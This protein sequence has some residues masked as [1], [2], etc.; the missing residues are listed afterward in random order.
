[1]KRL[2]TDT[3]KTLLRRKAIG[4]A[5][6]LYGEEDYLKN[7]SAERVVSAYV[8]EAARSF[9]FTELYR[10]LDIGRLRD[11][12]MALPMLSEKRV[13][14]L[15]DPDI[16]SGGEE[17]AEALARLIAELPEECVLVF[18]FIAEPLSFEQPKGRTD[19]KVARACKVFAEASAVCCDRLPPDKAEVW[20]TSL[21]AEKGVGIGRSAARALAELCGGDMY[22]IKNNADI[23]AAS[24]EKEITEKM[25]SRIT[26]NT[27]EEDSFRLAD[28]I[29]DGKWQEAYSI[30]DELAATKTDPR[31]PMPTVISGFVA[32]YRVAVATEKTG[33]WAPLDGKFTYL[34]SNYPLKKAAARIKGRPAEYFRKA[35][36]LCI[37]AD[38]RL[39]RDFAGYEAYYELIGG[40]AAL[41]EKA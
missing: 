9:D 30:L 1:M 13:V 23:L 17:Q 2:D 16:Y 31:E 33:S 19:R 7:L 11:L 39:K 8:D 18:V 35:A 6:V 10:E 25:L 4:G 5:I 3:L 26:Y 36:L 27:V 37:E 29:A 28:A 38:R 12:T 14:L 15:R 22:A 24:G 41:G 20:I 21:L 40:L 32:M 34:K